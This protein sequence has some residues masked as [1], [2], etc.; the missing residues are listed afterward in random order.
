M[1]KVWVCHEIRIARF[2]L[3]HCLILMPVVAYVCSKMHVL[4]LIMGFVLSFEVCT[5]KTAFLHG[6]YKM[7]SVVPARKLTADHCALYARFAA[8]CFGILGLGVL[9]FSPMGLLSSDM[10]LLLHLE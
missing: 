8:A 7:F 3:R 5:I 10:D 4:S 6:I 2:A 9:A 1:A